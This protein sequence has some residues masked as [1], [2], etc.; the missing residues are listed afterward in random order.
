MAPA[1]AKFL[2]IKADQFRAFRKALTLESDR[3]CALFA[4]AYLDKS[5]SEML[6]AS[7]VNSAKIEDDLF[8]SQ[9]PLGSFSARIKIAYYLGMLSKSE[10]HDLDIIRKVRNQ[11][12]HNSEPMTFD[13][14]S[15]QNLCSNLVHDWNEKDARP[16]AKFTA[17]ASALLASIH[18]ATHR[19]VARTEKTDTPISDAAKETVRHNA[20]ATVAKLRKK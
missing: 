17:T 3:G 14:V 20:R 19:G 11:F 16:R 10:R 13:Q 1:D 9:A 5:L 15:V 2:A 18:V 12:A 8:G 6:S 4:A 7:L